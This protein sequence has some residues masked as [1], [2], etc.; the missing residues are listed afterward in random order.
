MRQVLDYLC[1]TL[2][3]RERRARLVSLLKAWFPNKVL[4]QQTQYW[5][6]YADATETV[7]FLIPFGKRENGLVLGAHYDAV[8]RCPGANDNGASVVQLL[9]AAKWLA[10]AGQEPNVTFALFDH[11][12]HYGS[13]VMGSK[14]FVNQAWKTCVIPDK[15]VIFDVNGIGDVYYVSGEDETGLLLDLPTRHTPPSDDRNIRKLGIPT[16]LVC[17][18]PEHEF[19]VTSPDTWKLLHSMEDSPD[20]ISNKDLLGGT[21]LALTIVRRYANGQP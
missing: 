2:D 6:A 8:P 20:K 18:L 19:A 5:D 15:A 3:P 10:D 13:P 11:E 16:S 9:H 21:E 12:E 7:N 14:L 17:A 4:L 1:D